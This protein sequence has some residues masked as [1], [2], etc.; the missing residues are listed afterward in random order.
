M[1]FRSA[2]AALALA[3]MLTPGAVLAS[4]PE[5][6]L[7]DADRAAADTAAEQ[8]ALELMA[9]ISEAEFV[10]DLPA[11]YVSLDPNYDPLA[12]WTPD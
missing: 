11:D 3:A 10:I 8:L 4:Q 9:A 7:A 1:T 2:I 12:G 5:V 6:A